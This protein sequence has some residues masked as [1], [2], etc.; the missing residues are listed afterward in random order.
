[1]EDVTASYHNLVFVTASFAISAFFTSQSFISADTTV[2]SFKAHVCIFKAPD[3]VILPSH[4]SITTFF[5]PRSVPS[6]VQ[7]IFFIYATVLSKV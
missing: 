1:L 7:I 5:V 2:S 6:F 3:I 4:P